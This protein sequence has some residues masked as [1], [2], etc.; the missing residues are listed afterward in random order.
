MS[1]N[2]VLVMAVDNRVWFDSQSL[3]DYLRDM[4]QQA[5]DHLA[6]ARE[7]EDRRK[8]VAALAISDALRQVSDGLVLTSMSAMETIRGRR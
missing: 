1:M 2:N 6:C 4:E 3:I 5:K 8:E 7:E